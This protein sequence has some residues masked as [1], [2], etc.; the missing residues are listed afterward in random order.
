MDLLSAEKALH[1]I[2]DDTKEGCDCSDVSAGG[3]AQKGS[4][5]VGNECGKET[6]KDVQAEEQV[7]GNEEDKKYEEVQQKKNRRTKRSW[8]KAGC[9]GDDT[10]QKWNKCAKQAILQDRLCM[11]EL[12]FLCIYLLAL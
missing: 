11:Y 4:L 3:K 8:A 5:V 6:T 12:F 2:E 7:E 10:E 9:E 1:F